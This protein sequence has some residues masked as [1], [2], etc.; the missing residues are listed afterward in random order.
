[1]VSADADSAMCVKQ[2]AAGP[3]T[4]AMYVDNIKLAG[5]D[6]DMDPI[7]ARLRSKLDVKRENDDAMFVGMQRVTDAASSAITIHQQW[8]TEVLL[9]EFGM[10]NAKLVHT[11]AEPGVE[12]RHAAG[13]DI[14]LAPEVPYAQVVSK[15]MFLAGCTRP[16][17]MQPVAALAR[18][19][20]APQES[21]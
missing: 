12:L 2:G 18:Y 9:A 5:T 13:G 16:D 6:R 3:V 20:A 1:M 10:A 21:Y 14:A 11:P 19:M 8:Y 17:V 4:V 15:L 7:E